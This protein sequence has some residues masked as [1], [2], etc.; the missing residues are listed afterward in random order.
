MA[1]MLFNRQQQNQQPNN[2]LQTLQQIKAKGPS[3]VIF[4]Q[5]YQNNPD[6]KKFADSV[7]NKTPE[8][9][10]SEYGLDFNQFRDQRW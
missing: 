1:N 6:F 7:R 8:Q 3:N 10:F 9:A 2:P 4:Q 5:L